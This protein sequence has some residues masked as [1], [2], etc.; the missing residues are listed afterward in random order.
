MVNY[1]TFKYSEEEK[2]KPSRNVDIYIYMRT[3]LTCD[4]FIVKIFTF[5]N[6]SVYVKFLLLK[7]CINQA[8]SCTLDLK[9]FNLRNSGGSFIKTTTL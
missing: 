9:G 8:K 3:L 6:I 5:I 2:V 7:K 1:V 4:F